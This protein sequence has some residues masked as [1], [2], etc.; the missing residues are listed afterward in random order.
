MSRSVLVIGILICF[1]QF[2]Q[3]QTPTA[4]RQVYVEV[5]AL[6]ATTNRTPFWLRA[7]QFG[8]VPLTGQA[9]T[10]RAGLS[11]SFMLTDTTVGRYRVRDKSK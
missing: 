7:N 1:S 3:A 11:G 9:G 8:V 2:L 6:G 10:V 5:G 4:G